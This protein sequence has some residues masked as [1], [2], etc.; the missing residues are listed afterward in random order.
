MKSWNDYSLRF[1]EKADLAQVLEWRNSAPVRNSMLSS[2]P[3][4]W[5]QHAAWFEHLDPEANRYLVFQHREKKL[6]LVYLN[7]IDFKTLACEWGF[8]LGE[9][10]LPRGTGLIMGFLGLGYAFEELNMETVNAK[11]LASNRISLNYH[12]R[13]GFA[14][15][16]LREENLLFFTLTR[17]IWKKEKGAL[18]ILL[19]QKIKEQGKANA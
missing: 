4:S 7:S 19:L 15:Q 9:K 8:Y 12:Q 14:E 3:I 16:D 10:G 17:S 2:Q 13:L 18:E 11:V 1:L 5:K 6:G